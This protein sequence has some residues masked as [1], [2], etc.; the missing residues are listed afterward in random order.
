MPRQPTSRS[1][2][3][4][5]LDRLRNRVEVLAAERPH[6]LTFYIFLI[7][8]VI[9]VGISLPFWIYDTADFFQ[10]VMAEAHGVVLD[11]LIIGWLLFWLRKIGERRTITK[12]YTE[13]I[14]DYLAWRTPEATLRI[15]GNIR[16]LN[17]LQVPGPLKLTEAYLVDA[18][19]DDVD[20]EGANLWGADLSGASLTGAVLTDANLAGAILRRANLERAVMSR[21]DFRG[22]DLTEA[23]LERAFIEGADLRGANLTACDLQ[24]ASLPNANLGHARFLGANLRGAHLEHC[25]L[26][27]AV[28]DGANLQGASLDAADIRGADF[29]RADLSRADLTGAIFPDGHELITLFDDVRTLQGA[30]VPPH[31]EDRLRAQVPH[32]FS[33]PRL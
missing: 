30:K 2:P 17:R 7:A 3:G 20:L 22:A 32:I 24:F 9:V 8:A 21:T 29:T 25:D 11:I 23:D 4:G 16:R 33:P 19:L 28:F 18:R 27:M 6:H 14:E 5:R 26:K 13:E 12:R 1:Q 10:E 15:A 31:I